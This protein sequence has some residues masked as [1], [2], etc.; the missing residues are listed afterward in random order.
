MGVFKEEAHMFE[1]LAKNQ[2]QIYNDA[3]D[4]GYPY[5][6]NEPPEEVQQTIN[7]VKELQAL[8]QQFPEEKPLVRNR[9]TWGDKK[10]GGVSV[11]V[12]IFWESDGGYDFGTKYS[13]S[14]N[15][16]GKHATSLFNKECDC[17]ISIDITQYKE[18]TKK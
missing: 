5:K 18:R 8:D 4:Y 7:A 11:E 17:F 3:A 10:S 2:K 13:I 1:T 12:I 15:R 14:F 6:S 9:Q 16:T